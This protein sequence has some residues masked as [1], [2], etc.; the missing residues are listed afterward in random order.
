MNG[1]DELH[2]LR[3]TIKLDAKQQHG[4]N[5]TMQ[6][7]TTMA[8]HACLLSAHEWNFIACLTLA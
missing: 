1:L 2:Q 3:T 6:L 7:L 4:E 8:Q 5:V